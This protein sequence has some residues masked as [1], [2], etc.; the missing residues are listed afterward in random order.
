MYSASLPQVN[1]LTLT[2]MGS[3]D[4]IKAGERFFQGIAGRDIRRNI[5]YLDMSNISFRILDLKAFITSGLCNSFNFNVEE[6]YFNGLGN[7]DDAELIVN[8]I[9]PRLNSELQMKTGTSRVLVCSGDRHFRP[10]FALGEEIIRC[11]EDSAVIILAVSKHYCQKEWYR[12]E[13]HETYDRNKPIVLLFLERVEHAEMG[14][15]LQKLSGSR[16][17]FK[18][19]R[20]IENHDHQGGASGYTGV[21]TSGPVFGN[22]WN[23]NLAS[24][25]F[26]DRKRVLAY[27]TLLKWRS[28][29]GSTWSDSQMSE[30]VES[31]SIKAHPNSLFPELSGALKDL[32]MKFLSLSNAFLKEEEEEDVEEEEE[33]E[34][35]EE[36]EEDMNKTYKT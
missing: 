19:A 6:M 18:T 32:N 10:G 4:H 20:R 8:K 17:L 3:R 24:W 9:L 27:V 29:G 21:M 14:K 35:V 28:V 36:E 33:E 12:K 1:K 15:V 11:I 16:A 23:S 22:A 31:L 30:S 25:S 7:A 13:V 34:E 26:S 5:T 2:G